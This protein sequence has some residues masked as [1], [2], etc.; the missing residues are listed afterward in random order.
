MESFPALLVIPWTLLTT[1]V[2]PAQPYNTTTQ[3]LPPANLAPVEQAAVN[4]ILEVEL[5]PYAD[6]NLVSPSTHI[7]QSAINALLDSTGTQLLLP[8][9]AKDAQLML[10]AVTTP[11]VP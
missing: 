8:Q 1:S 9:P 5:F 10:L 11:T 6:A 3:L 4:S 7:T 2:I